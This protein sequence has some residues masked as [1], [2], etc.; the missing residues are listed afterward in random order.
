MLRINNK[1]NLNLL[2]VY[3][4]IICST[5]KI[6]RRNRIK[7]RINNAKIREVHKHLDQGMDLPY[8]CL[9]LQKADVDEDWWK[10]LI[11]EKKKG[12]YPRWNITQY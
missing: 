12:K 7:K 5:R 4:N 1:F 8:P 9:C 6:Y 3:P 11:K 2:I 10:E